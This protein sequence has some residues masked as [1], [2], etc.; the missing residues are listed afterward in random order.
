MPNYAVMVDI[1]DRP[2]PQITY[3]PQENLREAVITQVSLVL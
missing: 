1:R 3:V 2:E